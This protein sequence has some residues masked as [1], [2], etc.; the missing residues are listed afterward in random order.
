MNPPDR[1]LCPALVFT[2][3]G[4]DASVALA[5]LQQAGAE[6]IVCPDLVRFSAMLSDAISCAVVT[7]EALRGGDLRALAAWVAAQPPWS[8]FPFIVLTQ[9]RGTPDGDARLAELSMMLGNVTFLERPFHPTTF[10]S[11]VGTALRGRFRQFEA[12]SR[13]EELHEGE[14]RLHTALT[15]GQLGSWELDLLTSGLITSATCKAIFGR[16]LNADFSYG[17]LVASVHPDDRDRVQNAMRESYETGC[18][19]TIECRTVWPDATLHWAELR[20]R[21]VRD[22]SPGGMRLVG[23]ASDVTAR[24][25]AEDSLRRVNET[26][27]AKVAERTAELERAH[28]VVLDEIR[29]RERTEELLRQVQKMEMI[30]QITGG[31][32]H[33]FN[34]L[35]MAVMGN[36]ELLRKQTPDDLKAGRLIDGALKGAQRGAALTQRL[37]AFA[38]QQDLK[39]E[40]THLSHLIRGITDLLERSIGSQIELKLDLPETLPL[41]LVDANQI[42]LALLNLVVN[43]RD[44]MPE[45]GTLLISVDVTNSSGRDEL[46]AG[47][48][49]CLTVSDTGKGMDAATLAKATEPFFTTKEL[50]KGTGLGLSMI[51][52]LA[53]QLNGSLRLESELERGTRASLWLPVTSQDSIALPLAQPKPQDSAIDSIHATILVVDDDA[54]I[55]SSTAYLLEDLGHEV[56]EADSGANALEVLKNGQKVDLLITD[57]SMPKMTGVQLA[58]AARELRPNLPILL[59]TGYADLPQG[60]SLDIPRLRKPY[61]QHQLVA[62]IARALQHVRAH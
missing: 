44:A 47:D 16:L 20:A 33:D 49:L 24:K 39:I 2:P 50:G 36:L 18:D 43:A 57:Y 21:L 25:T 6:A 14:A 4:R 11:V 30:G 10:I 1:N 28:Q 32:A 17:Q 13:I 42:E 22:G 58:V 55:A 53:L 51:H 62:E 34:N 35:L 46:A 40:P 15:A 29:Q 61:Q 9:R 52:G 59:A 7:E 41:T 37:L 31:V 5:L 12:R 3:A 48:Y 56:I 38:R 19:F 26:L 8:D 23:V 60:A 27:E 45:G 54:L